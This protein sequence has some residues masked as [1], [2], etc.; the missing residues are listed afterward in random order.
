[1][2]TK[3]LLASF[4]LLSLEIAAQPEQDYSE[5]YGIK[6]DSHVPETAVSWIAE[7]AVPMEKALKRI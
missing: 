4:L 5:G 7:E 6:P 1:M 3:L 2:Q